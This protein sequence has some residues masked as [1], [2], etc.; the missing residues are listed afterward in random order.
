MQRV[1]G[2]SSYYMEIERLVCAASE[3]N[4]EC[5]RQR[6]TSTNA[7]WQ[8]HRRHYASAESARPANVF[9]YYATE[10]PERTGALYDFSHATA[11][12]PSRGVLQ[13]AA[14]APHNHPRSVQYRWCVWRV[15]L[16][17][18]FAVPQPPTTPSIRATAFGLHTIKF[19]IVYFHWLSAGPLHLVQTAI[20]III[21]IIFHA[22]QTQRTPMNGDTTLTRIIYIVLL[23][24]FDYLP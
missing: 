3:F 13:R 21:I 16:L 7:T 2:A 15:Q 1:H 24:V 14:R 10:F 6:W 19:R 20:I 9:R 17:C 5:Y 18:S 8:P 11:A 12:R 23:R 22:I 4:H